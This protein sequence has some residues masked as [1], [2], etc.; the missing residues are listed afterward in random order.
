MSSEIARATSVAVDGQAALILGPSGSGKS[1]LALELIALGAELVS[2]D[3]TGLFLEGGVL[4]ARPVESISGLIEARGAGILRVTPAAPARVRLAVDL[5]RPETERLPP[6]RT[7]EFLG[8]RVDLIRGQ[9]MPGL[10]SVV[11]VRMR[12]RR[13]D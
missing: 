13:V 8:H 9:G 12:A 11:T 4:M 10:A 6:R 7:V 2:D 3:R 5:E 1:L